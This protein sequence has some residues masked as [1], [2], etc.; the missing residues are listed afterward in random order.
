MKLSLNNFLIGIKQIV[1]GSNRPA[2]VGGVP[3]ADGGFNLDV[4]YDLGDVVLG[5]GTTFTTTSNVPLLSNAASNTSIGTITQ[6]IPRDYDE[7]SDKF[8]VRVIAKSAGGT[9]SP[10]ITIASSTTVLGGTVGVTGSTVVSGATSSTLTAYEFDL[11][12]QGLV[13]DAILSATITIGAHTTDAF[14][15][16]AIEIVYSSCVVSYKDTTDALGNPL[17]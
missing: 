3:G 11:S 16:F 4:T 8:L 17:R 5:S 14:Q 13:R 7:A 6:L 2:L 12:G 9:N 15:V 1:T 10:T